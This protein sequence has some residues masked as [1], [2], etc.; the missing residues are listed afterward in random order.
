MTSLR[1][2]HGELLWWWRTFSALFALLFLAWGWRLAT[3]A[4]YPLAIASF[5]ACSS[6]GL[7]GLVAHRRY[8]G[9]KRA[10]RE[11]R[12]SIERGARERARWWWNR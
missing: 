11:H 1:R 4:Q 2:T 7:G 3:N 5:A 6:C 8:V 10:R 9:W 12:R